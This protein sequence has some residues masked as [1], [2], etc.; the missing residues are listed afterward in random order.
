MYANKKGSVPKLNPPKW[1]SKERVLQEKKANEAKQLKEQALKEYADAN[2]ASV[3][4]ETNGVSEP[5]AADP[6]AAAGSAEPKIPN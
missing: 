1:P 6:Q 5:Q 2:K 4:A 3:F